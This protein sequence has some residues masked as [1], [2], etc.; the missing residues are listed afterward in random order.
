MS[1]LLV[2]LRKYP[3][4]SDSY[5]RYLEWLLCYCPRVAR[6]T[7][8]W[9]N[10][11][12]CSLRK[13]RSPSL[14]RW[15]GVAC[16]AAEKGTPKTCHSRGTVQLEPRSPHRT[17]SLLSA[18]TPVFAVAW[19]ATTDSCPCPNTRFWPG[20]PSAWIRRPPRTSL[21]SGAPQQPRLALKG[22]LGPPLPAASPGSVC[23]CSS[24]S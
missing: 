8:R 12:A 2:C 22:W 16:M 15:G 14:A 10:P 3:P 9:R 6:S 21:R 4:E 20:L 23:S 1:R 7:S 19:A 17:S 13:R 5:C 11:P 24:A 18:D